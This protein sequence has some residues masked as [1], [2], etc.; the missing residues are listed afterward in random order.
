[1]NNDGIEFSAMERDNVEKLRAVQP[2]ANRAA[3]SV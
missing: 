2:A 1:M 3:R